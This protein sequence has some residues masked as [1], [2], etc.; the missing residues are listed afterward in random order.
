MKEYSINGYIICVGDGDGGVE[1]S[2]ER[3][4]AIIQSLENK[5]Q[6]TETIDYKLKTNL[7]WEEYEIDHKP[8]PEPEPE[9]EELLGI[10]L[11][12]ES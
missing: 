4:A 11:G 10:L 1:I 5:P 2:D 6:P 12:G 7:T 8:E 9:A 3:Y